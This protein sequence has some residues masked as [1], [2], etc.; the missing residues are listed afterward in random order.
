[1][2]FIHA[3]DFHLCSGYESSSLPKPIAKERREQL[4]TTFHSLIDTCRE[5]RIDVL[6]ISGDLYEN[7]YAKISDV[8]RIADAF[9]SI[10]ETRVFISCGNHDPYYD[11]SYYNIIAFPENVHIFPS[12]YSSVELKEHNAVI[13]GFSWDKNAYK[14]S[15]FTFSSIDPNKINILCLHCDVLTKSEYL[16]LSVQAIDDIGFDYAALGHI[17]KTTQ[18]KSQ[19]FYSG[20][21]EPLDFGEEGKHGYYLGKITDKK[22]KV[23]FIDSAKRAFVSKTIK[24]SGEMDHNHIRDLILQESDEDMKK[25][26]FRIK[27]KGM[28]DPQVSLSSVVNE[29][30]DR[31]YCLLYKD[32]TVP[33]YDIMKLYR[34]NKDNIIG[35]YIESLLKQAEADIVAYKALIYGLNALL[36]QNGGAK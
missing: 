24:L 35:K 3:S 12:E 26:I 32:L 5:D 21:P 7:D 23:K 20:S 1:M 34:Q 13:Y 31:F 8:K 33:D 25:N 22:S 14:Q 17:H 2:K 36:E 29:L 10:P 19:I 30:K 9:A 16:P 15:P 27:F 11:K 4:W 18:V 28:V 6:L